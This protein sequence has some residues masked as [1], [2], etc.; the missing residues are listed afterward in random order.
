MPRP[1][2]LGLSFFIYR[3]EAIPDMSDMDTDSD[4]EC[5]AVSMQGMPGEGD[6]DVRIRRGAAPAVALRMLGTVVAAIETN[7]YK[8]L[9]EHEGYDAHWVD[10]TIEEDILSHAYNPEDPDNPPVEMF[11]LPEEKKNDGGESG[12]DEDGKEAE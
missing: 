1:R 3:P 10:G 4:G 12:G 6:V 5:V 11:P 2:K 8:L 7:G 9:N